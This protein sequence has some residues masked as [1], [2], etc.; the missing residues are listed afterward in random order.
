MK[1]KFLTDLKIYYGS[2]VRAI[3][4]FGLSFFSVSVVGGVT[5]ANLES[6]FIAGGLYMFAEI[7]RKYGIKNPHSQN[8]KTNFLLFP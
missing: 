3:A 8:N 1:Q 5:T 4:V 7:I 2:F 6:S